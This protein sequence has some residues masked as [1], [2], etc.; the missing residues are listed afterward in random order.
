MKSRKYDNAILDNGHGRPV[1][2]REF[3]GRGL[4]SGLGLVMAPGLLGFLARTPD[5]YAQAAECGVAT[6]VAGKVPFLAFDLAG[7][8]SIAGS[9]VMVGGQ[10]G[11][12]DFLP[13]AG[14]QKLG[15][16]ADM[17]PNLPGQLNS[18]LGLAFHADSALLRG[19]LSKT[20]AATRANTNGAIFAAR[21]EN[22]TGN[23][24]HNPMYGIA[25]AG[26]V[27]DLV[28][29]IG[30]R[31]SESG[32]KSR[33]PASMVDL[34]VR[35]TKVDR[36]NDAMGLVDTGKLTSL[37]SGADAARVMQAIEQ[38]SAAKINK[39]TE[40]AV[41]KQ[42]L[43]CSYSQTSDMVARFGDPS[44]LD[45]TTDT[46]LQA[47][48][49]NGQI[50]SNVD[51]RKSAAVLKLVVNGFAGAGTIELAGYDYHNSTR[52][53]GEQKDF[54][55]GQAIGAALEYA[56]QLNRPLMIYVFSDGAVDSNGKLDNSANGRGKG[57]WKG[58]N[59]STASTFIL[60]YNPAGRPVLTSASNQQIGYFKANG[61]L[62]LTATPISNNVDQLAAAVVLN[63]MALNNEV[64]RFTSVLPNNGLGSALDKLVAFQP[65]V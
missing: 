24:P 27:G 36:A 44:L 3:L 32:G 41:V 42:L 39:L 63:Y 55:A 31:T 12:L 46:R 51:F 35:P 15:L 21:S 33:A 7:G 47:L 28:T 37:M 61:S 6:G 62:E 58:D 29:L 60:V 49:P 25:K 65:I 23:N 8:A 1:T 53:T 10:G 16:P 18:E 43:T 48:F 40:Q 9:N 14:Y 17:L 64:G 26:A 30:T 2:R 54:V 34:S 50:T 5:A 52:A 56:A 57:I 20:T 4:I 13:A 11:Q 45:P 22:D 19:I 59:S 38:L